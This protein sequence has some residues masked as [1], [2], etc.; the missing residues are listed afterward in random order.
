MWILSDATEAGYEYECPACHK[1]VDVRNAYDLPNDCPYCHTTNMKQGKWVK[2]RDIPLC[3][4]CGSVMP[5]CGAG[6]T[7]IDPSMV[8]F[9]HWCGTPMERYWEEDDV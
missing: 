7:N 2:V 1:H 6:A 4:Q 8:R 9:C 5:D 3:N